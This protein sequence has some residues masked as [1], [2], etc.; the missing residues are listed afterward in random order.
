MSVEDPRHPTPRGKIHS[1]KISDLA[2]PKN[3]SLVVK[4]ISVSGDAD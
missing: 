4:D 1:L 3:R 2:P